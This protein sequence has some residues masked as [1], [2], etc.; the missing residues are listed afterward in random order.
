MLPP[1]KIG[2]YL[3]KPT[4]VTHCQ[5]ELSGKSQTVDMTSC[6]ACS[7]M[8]EHLKSESFKKSGFCNMDFVTASPCFSYLHNHV[9]VFGMSTK[10][11]VG[12]ERSQCDGFLQFVSS[13]NATGAGGT[14]TP[15]CSWDRWWAGR[16]DGFR[17]NPTWTWVAH[18][19][20][21]LAALGGNIT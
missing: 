10:L 19:C 2:R 8:V 16:D 6:D 5:T 7:K 9:M 12:G 13:C 18:G 21:F 14:S 1:G 4:R 11:R 17:W 15:L 20:T 3:G